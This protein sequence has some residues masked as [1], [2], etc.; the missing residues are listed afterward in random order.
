[1]IPFIRQYPGTRR[2][3]TEI[4]CFPAIEDL[5]RE[6]IAQGGKY[7]IEILP[8][9]QV[10][11]VACLLANGCQVDIVEETVEN[12]PELLNAVNRIIGKS[13]NYFVMKT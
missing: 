8:S 7:L 5:A 11:V 10:R 12:G 3:L 9:Q 6:F 13:V 4:S 1:M 2:G